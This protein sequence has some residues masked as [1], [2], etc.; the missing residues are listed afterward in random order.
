MQCCLNSELSGCEGSALGLLLKGE[1][2]EDAVVFLESQTA[3]TSHIYCSLF[4]SLLAAMAQVSTATLA[5]LPSPLSC[6]KMSC[7]ATLT[8]CGNWCPRNSG[9]ICHYRPHTCYWLFQLSVFD[10]LGLLS[11]SNLHPPPPLVSGHSS[12]TVGMTTS[13]SA[14]KSDVIVQL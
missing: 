2:W 11:R 3:L 9:K 14:A 1:L 7:I 4:Q 8:V 12:L 5:R 10:L 13:C 6:R